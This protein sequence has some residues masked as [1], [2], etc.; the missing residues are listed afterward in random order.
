MLDAPQVIQT[1]F[2]VSGLCTLLQTCFG[3]RL[4]II[5]VCR[6]MHNRSASSALSSAGGFPG[7]RQCAHI[8]AAT[9]M[10][11]Q[12]RLAELWRSAILYM[13][14]GSFAYL[15][16]AFAIIAQ[17]RWKSCVKCLPFPTH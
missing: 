15:Q 12:S 17:V 5:Q 10:L 1:I 14:G 4:P 3:D 9:H 2:F 16:P 11:Q 7:R 8:Y 6:L 13:Q